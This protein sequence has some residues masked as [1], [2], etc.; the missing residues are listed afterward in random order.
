MSRKV[1]ARRAAGVAEIFCERFPEVEGS[2]PAG[3][4]FMAAG[5]LGLG[6]GTG[7]T[8]SNVSMKLKTRESRQAWAGGC[9]TVWAWF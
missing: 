3:D 1:V 2:V 9:I 8:Y 5:G 6:R 7:A 4:G